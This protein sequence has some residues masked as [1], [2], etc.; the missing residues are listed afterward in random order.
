[1]G[2]TQEL[3]SPKSTHWIFFFKKKKRLKED[4]KLH[5]MHHASTYQH[6]ILSVPHLNSF[7]SFIYV[8]RL[9]IA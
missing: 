1:M 7:S 2:R 3:G 8:G 5:Q 6:H 4:E 9:N